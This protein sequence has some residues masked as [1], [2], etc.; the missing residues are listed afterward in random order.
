[1]ALHSC[2]TRRSKLAKLRCI[3]AAAAA[4][5][6]EQGVEVLFGFVAPSESVEHL[7]QTD[8]KHGIDLEML[9]MT[10]QVQLNQKLIGGAPIKRGDH[11][12]KRLVKRPLA[13]GDGQMLTQVS[14]PN[15]ESQTLASLKAPLGLRHPQSDQDDPDR[16]RR[17]RPG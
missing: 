16:D 7:V 1:M 6:A 4:K 15:K 5:S 3:K 8:G 13:I 12:G 2:F 14:A 9:L 10:E 11:I 17:I